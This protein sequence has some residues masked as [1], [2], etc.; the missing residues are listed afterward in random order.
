MWSLYSFVNNIYKIV[1]ITSLLYNHGNLTLKLHH[2]NMYLNEGQ[3]S[4]GRFQIGSLPRM[5]NKEILALY[6]KLPNHL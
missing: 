4:T 1:C 5:I 2:K 6:I 3:L